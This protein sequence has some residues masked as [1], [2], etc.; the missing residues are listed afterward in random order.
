MGLKACDLDLLKI[1]T[2]SS[3]IRSN[4]YIFDATQI[5]SDNSVRFSVA[6][7]G[8]S[9]EI[10]ADFSSCIAA[11]NGQRSSEKCSWGE[12]CRRDADEQKDRKSILS[13]K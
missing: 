2:S 12:S 7:E 8:T 1:D 10:V 11:L 6:E 9:N 4:R 13:D 3:F 5:D